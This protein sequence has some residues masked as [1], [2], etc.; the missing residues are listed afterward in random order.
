MRLFHVSEES[1]ITRFEPRTPTREDLDPN[2]KLV[3]AINE[4]CLPNF[5]TPR[6]CPR[7]AYHC[8]ETTTEEDKQ[9]FLSSQSLQHVVA[10][11]HKWFEIMRS[12]T[13]Y[14]YEFDPAGFYVQESTAGYYVSEITQVPIN[15]IMM[16]D[17]FGELIN[18]NV[19][20]RVMDHLWDLSDK[21]Q[22]TS[23]N[24]SMCRMRFARGRS[25]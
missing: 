11:E 10:I 7:V 13:L 14:V 16:D 25:Q 12:T 1:E 6:N 17:L 15:R 20:V 4:R 5:L 24:W 2:T 3:W 22:Q 21:I 23:F 18:R 8:N 19:E 9:R